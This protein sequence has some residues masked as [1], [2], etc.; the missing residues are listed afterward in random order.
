[1]YVQRARVR[2]DVSLFLFLVRDATGD[3]P[4]LSQSWRISLIIGREGD[5]VVG[6]HWL[7]L[8][9]LFPTN[10]QAEAESLASFFNFAFLLAR[11]MEIGRV[12]HHPTFSL[13]L[14]SQLLFL[15]VSPT[16]SW[17]LFY[18][19]RFATFSSSFTFQQ[20]NCDRWPS[21]IRRTQIDIYAHGLRTTPKSPNDADLIQSILFDYYYLSRERAG[22]LEIDFMPPAGTIF[23]ILMRNKPIMYK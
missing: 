4:H 17:S 8:G 6:S 3:G 18:S 9:S 19:L 2:P 13:F 5:G 11:R 10:A 14:L 22:S 7:A 12:S 21:F 20:G 23:I 16:R 15:F 1:M